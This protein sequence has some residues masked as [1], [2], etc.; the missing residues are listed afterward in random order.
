HHL[1]QHVKDAIDTA[2]RQHGLSEA[3]A[4]P[5]LRSDLMLLAANGHDPTDVLSRAVALGGLDGARDPA[6]VITYRLDLTQANN[7]TRGPLPWLPGIP[8]GLLDDP[9]WKTYLT[10][11]YKLTRQ[12]G[13]ETRHAAD[14]AKTPPGWAEHLPGLDPDLVADIQL[15]R[16]A[17]QIPDIDLRP[18][19][20]PQPSAAERNAQRRL[21]HALETSH[22]GIREWS[23]RITEAAPAVAGDPRLPILAARLA[24]LNPTRADVPELLATAAEQGH[25]PDDHPADALSYRITTLIKQQQRQTPTWETV[26]SPD[27][28]RHL[29][30]PPPPSHRPDRGP[31]ISI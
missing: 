9:Y 6:A 7:R 26:T 10:D 31:G 17:N 23:P 15:W 28:T 24:T 19:G 8:T 29:H 13:Q 11:R 20:P 3:D 27:L 30:H 12:L 14:T 5:T 4:W 16:A 18:T 25:L 2:G 21:D 1:P 22:A